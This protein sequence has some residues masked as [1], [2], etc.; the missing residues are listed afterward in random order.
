MT[1][2]SLSEPVR[3]AAVQMQGRVGD[4]RYNLDHI[5]TLAR[6]AAQGGAR[7]IALPEFFTTPIIYDER[8]YECALLPDNFALERLQDIAT[9]YNVLIGGSYLEL[10]GEDV[11]NCYVLVEPSGTIHRHDKD[12]PTMVE[13]AFYVGGND[14]GLMDTQ[15]GPIGVAVCWETIRK[16]TVDR[17]A[18]KVDLLMT[19]SHWWSEPGWAFPRALFN[20]AHR[21]NIALMQAAPGIFAKLVGAPVLHAAHCGTI[22]GSYLLTT[23]GRRIATKTRLMG[24]TQ[25]VSADG[26]ILAR[27]GREAGPGVIFADIDLSTTSQPN[28]P[29]NRFWI[30]KL[31][32]LF[33]L[34]WLQQNAC[35]K[36]AYKR[37]KAEGRI[38]PFDF[39]RNDL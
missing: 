35:G 22:A 21:R 26:R 29:P 32:L 20:W 30:P 9:K 16:R 24:E 37:A 33:K 25:I 17:L 4:V 6:E 34:F 18:G 39:A 31:P 12:Q 28:A 14:T 27:R 1:L 19:G 2:K 15:D 5:I 23:G 13:N 8:L 38:K 10:R 11:Y 7:V 3:V 36:S